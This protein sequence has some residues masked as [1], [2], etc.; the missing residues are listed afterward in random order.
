M[1][2]LP[3]NR[4][5]RCDIKA[6]EIELK[7]NHST[8][9]IMGSGIFGFSP[10]EFL[11][12]RAFLFFVRQSSDIAIVAPDPANI[13]QF[14][15]FKNNISKVPKWKISSQIFGFEW[16]ERN[17]RGENRCVFFFFL[18]FYSISKRNTTLSQMIFFSPFSLSLCLSF[19]QR[20]FNRTLD[21]SCV[22]VWLCVAWYHF[23][24]FTRNNREQSRLKLSV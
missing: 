23:I 18:L 15:K 12:C 17:T 7:V 6:I 20:S 13:Y 14:D 16:T 19:L 2:L 22:C 9:K 5:I 1:S 4:C 21:H 3:L 8:E 11:L 10:I 24:F